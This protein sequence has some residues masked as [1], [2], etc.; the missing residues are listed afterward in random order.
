LER[1]SLRKKQSFFLNKI[2]S[3]F[4]TH[5]VIANIRMI[6]SIVLLILALTKSASAV[7]PA[8]ALFTAE[9]IA[10]LVKVG[11]ISGSSKEVVVYTGTAC[12]TNPYCII[13]VAALGVI[14]TLVV[15]NPAYCT[16]DWCTSSSYV[17]CEGT[18]NSLGLCE[19]VNHQLGATCSTPANLP[20][21]GNAIAAAT[22]WYCIWY[23][24]PWQYQAAN[25]PII[26]ELY[27]EDICFRMTITYAMIQ[28]KDGWDKNI[29][30]LETTLAYRT[31]EGFLSYP[32]KKGL[33]EGVFKHINIKSL[34]EVRSMASNPSNVPLSAIQAYA[35]LYFE[36]FHPHFG[37]RFVGD[38]VGTFGKCR[39][40]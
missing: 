11:L 21:I 14:T 26:H 10:A 40:N 39:E 8:T 9:H 1:I 15:A 4:N 38:L 30:G 36:H 17:R 22:D 16:Y 24:L 5:K 20:V 37:Y 13:P 6:L 33:K 25:T 19:A 28:Q 2:E 3:I 34:S 35:N 27:I 23:I 31:S 32:A 29:N 12:V 18:T 7:E